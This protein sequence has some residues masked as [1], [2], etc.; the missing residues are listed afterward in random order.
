MYIKHTKKQDFRFF[1]QQFLDKLLFHSFPQS[2]LSES[3][4]VAQLSWATY[5]R[6]FPLSDLSDLLT[7]THLS[8][9]IWSKRSQSLIWFERNEQMRDEQMSEVPALR[10]RHFGWFWWL[11]TFFLCVIKNTDQNK[12]CVSII[13]KDKTKE[14]YKEKFCLQFLLQNSKMPFFGVQPIFFFFS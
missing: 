6:S 5:G 8:W 12:F 10:K 13:F 2:D 4:T 14:K 7:V 11:I 1:S 9:G 3:L